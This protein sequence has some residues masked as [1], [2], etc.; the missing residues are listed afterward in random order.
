MALENIPKGLPERFI[1]VIKQQGLLIGLQ[2][3][4]PIDLHFRI[5]AKLK[6]QGITHD[7]VVLLNLTPL[8]ELISDPKDIE[9]FINQL[10][11]E[12]GSKTKVSTAKVKY[13][14][15]LYFAVFID[16]PKEGT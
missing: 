2:A 4:C 6:Y 9:F 3:L 12:K 11:G 14:K 16:K 10:L 15:E 13:E 8:T 7:I 5:L 1:N